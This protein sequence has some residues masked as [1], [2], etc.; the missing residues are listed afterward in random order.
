MEKISGIVKASPRLMSVD[1]KEA[2][3]V[4]PGTPGFGRPEGVSSLR[5]Q[6]NFGIAAPKSTGL[7]SELMD[8]RSKDGQRA[9]VASD[10]SDRFF[11]RN[12]SA[13]PDS[14]PAHME[15]LQASSALNPQI[16]RD[17]ASKPSGF[18]SGEFSARTAMPVEFSSATPGEESSELQQ[19]E[20]LFPKG[21]FLDRTV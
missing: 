2:S 20:G 14:T 16:M 5:E 18:K 17:V 21:S 15:P 1:M 6:A 8:W 10:L 3:P 19:P 12:R 4:R 9:A 7:Q 13:A 11:M